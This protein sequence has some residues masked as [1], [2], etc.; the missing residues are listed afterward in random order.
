VATRVLEVGMSRLDDVLADAYGVDAHLAH[1]YLMSN[2]ENCQDRE[3]CRNAYESIAVELMRAMNFYRFSNPNSVLSDL[4]LCGGGAVIKPLADEI[5]DML[6]L[7]L[8]PATELVPGGDGI[9][10]CNSFVQAIG[11]AMS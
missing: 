6:D 5:G 11:I 10:S 9:E 4:W 8:H 3:E 2:Y 1:T 7:Q